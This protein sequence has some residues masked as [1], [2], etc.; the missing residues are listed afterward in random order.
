MEHVERFFV[1]ILDALVETISSDD[2][3]TQLFGNGSESKLV[4]PAMGS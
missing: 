3:A 2:Q 1:V 4:T